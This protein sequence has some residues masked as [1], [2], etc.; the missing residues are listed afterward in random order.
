MRDA[1]DFFLAFGML[2]TG[3]VNTIVTKFADGVCE[4]NEHDA[5]L[6]YDPKQTD[7]APFWGPAGTTPGGSSHEDK[8]LYNSDNYMKAKHAWLGVIVRQFRTH[9][10]RRKLIT[11]TLKT[12]I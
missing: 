7:F 8:Q 2:A 11:T 10:R 12:M 6:L 3:S 9:V 5:P 4:R 1:M